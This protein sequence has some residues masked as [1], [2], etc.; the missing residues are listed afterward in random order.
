MSA[1]FSKEIPS[2]GVLA[3]EQEAAAHLNSFVVTFSCIEGSVSKLQTIY[4]SMK[5]STDGIT[6]TFRAILI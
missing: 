1:I 4:H 2:F 5:E 6:V 3:S